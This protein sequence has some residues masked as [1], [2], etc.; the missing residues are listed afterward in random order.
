MPPLLPGAVLGVLGGGQLGRM[1]TLAARRM[2]YRVAVF[3]P[4]GDTPAGQ[5]A[6]QVF[7]ASYDDLSAVAEFSKQVEVVTFEFENVPTETAQEAE[8]HAPVRPRGT[9]LYTTQDRLREK[10]AL[11]QLGI[12]VAAHC[13]IESAADLSNAAE[14]IPGKSVLKT[15]AW[16]YDGKGQCRVASAAELETAWNTMENQPCVLEEMV[17]FE[18]EVSVVGARGL[19]GDIVLYDVFQNEHVNHILDL[20]IWPADLP[21]TVREKA[22][23][24]ARALFEGLE[25]VGVMCVEMFLLPDGNLKVNELAPRPHNSGHLTIDA[26]ATSQFE[27][28]VRAVCGLPLGSAEPRRGGAAMANLL[29]DLWQDGPP[30]WPGALAVPGVSLHLYGKDQARP[31]RKMGHLTALAPSPPEAAARV[32]RA[33]AALDLAAGS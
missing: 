28:Q 25:V 17:P 14:K 24:I 18:R 10:A 1:F 12:P 13:S 27:Q 7:R 8:R 31:G 19:D 32:Q 33:R 15:A 9:L 20:T 16:G 4:E 6:D 30:N 26:C 5:I 22:H 3:A 29:G 11:V 23:E 21:P 2:G